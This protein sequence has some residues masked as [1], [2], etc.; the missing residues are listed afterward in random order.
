MKC[1]KCDNKTDYYRNLCAKCE[2]KHVEKT[3][4]ARVKEGR[5]GGKAM[6]TVKEYDIINKNGTI[7]SQT[8]AKNPKE[9]QKNADKLDKS[10]AVSKRG[11][12]I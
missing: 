1:Q 12:K 6:K 9:A 11:R 8:Y 4:Q 7:I 3:L 10:L 5:K 2:L